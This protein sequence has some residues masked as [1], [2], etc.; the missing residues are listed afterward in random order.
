MPSATM[1]NEPLG[2]TGT[3]QARE[4]AEARVRDFVE[5]TKASLHNL[6]EKIQLQQRVET[7]PWRTLGVALAAGYVVGGGLFSPLT[8]R[9]LGLGLRIG[10]R[11]AALPMI[12]QELYSLAGSIRDTDGGVS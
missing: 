3:S 10:L 12:R 6:E 11:A 8:A 7:H 9:L 4:S 5:S 1:S 2:S